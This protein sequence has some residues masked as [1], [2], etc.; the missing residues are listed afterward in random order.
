[1]VAESMIYPLFPEVPAKRFLTFLLPAAGTVAGVSQSAR[2]RQ[3]NAET[4]AVHSQNAK[5]K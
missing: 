5:L 1:M 3:I 2:Y 4:H